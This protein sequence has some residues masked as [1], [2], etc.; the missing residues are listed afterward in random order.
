MCTKAVAE[1]CRIRHWLVSGLE[2]GMYVLTIYY[3]GCPIRLFFDLNYWRWDC[4]AW[5]VTIVLRKKRELDEVQYLVS[6]NVRILLSPRYIK[7]YVYYTP[8]WRRVKLGSQPA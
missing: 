3:L 7:S 8:A 2:F 4:G 5:E 1:R 6:C